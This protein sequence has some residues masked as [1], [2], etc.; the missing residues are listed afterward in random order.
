MYICHYNY[1]FG[2]LTHFTSVSFLTI[3]ITTIIWC[4]TVCFMHYLTPHINKYIARAI[5]FC[6]HIVDAVI[7]KWP[8]MTYIC[9]YHYIL[10][11]S[12]ENVIWWLT[13]FTSVSLL[14]IFTN[15]TIW[16][17]TVSFMYYLIP[18][19][20]KYLASHI[21]IYA[22]ISGRPICSI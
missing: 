4:K 5:F 15:K 18:H 20:Y 10:C 16:R 14:N 12:C 13:H 22:H 2:W 17:N 8:F 19:I 6:A 9:H 21:F 1:I 3:F 11:S 7:V